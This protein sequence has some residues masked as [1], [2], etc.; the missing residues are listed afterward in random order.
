MGLVSLPIETVELA[1]RGKYTG[2]Y[3]HLVMVKC[4]ILKIKSMHKSGSW[5]PIVYVYRTV[6]N[7][8]ELDFEKRKKNKQPMAALL[9]PVE[10]WSWGL[11]PI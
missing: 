6:F 10:G 11:P 5:Q 9:T 4:N 8:N 7:N 1:I 3:I 2:I